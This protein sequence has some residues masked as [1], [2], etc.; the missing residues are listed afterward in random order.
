ML[1]NK[2]P[3]GATN[4][5]TA[6]KNALTGNAAPAG[7]DALA[8]NPAPT[9]TGT[10]P[11]GAAPA[12]APAGAGENEITL[13]ERRARIDAEQK[14][15]EAAE[16]VEFEKMYLPLVKAH[17]NAMAVSQTI[18]KLQSPTNEKGYIK[19][20]VKNH[21]NSSTNVTSESTLKI[22]PEIMKENAAL[23]SK[24][25]EA[26]NELNIY[27]ARNVKLKVENSQEYRNI[28]QTWLKNKQEAEVAA[29]Q[30]KL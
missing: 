16:I 25:L 14:E 1:D 22:T 7:N 13:E 19:V 12:P 17:D 4:A 20:T 26:W 27:V 24:F 21:A 10:E 30:A 11:A 5:A 28:Y 3:T 6:V 18:Q 29:A 2:V 8:G 23:T 9:D 15:L